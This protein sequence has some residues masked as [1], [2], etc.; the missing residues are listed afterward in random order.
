MSYVSA[1]TQVVTVGETARNNDG[2]NVLQISV[3]V[4]QLNDGTASQ[5][6]S[7]RSVT[8]IQGA[9]ESHHANACVSES[10]VRGVAREVANQGDFSGCEGLCHRY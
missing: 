8:V 10:G 9:G 1:C 6:D 4:P 7:T 2:I 5:T 3:V